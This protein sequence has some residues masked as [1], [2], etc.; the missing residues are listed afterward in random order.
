MRRTE[1]VRE[2]RPSA[3]RESARLG[4]LVRAGHEKLLLAEL[5]PGRRGRIE[6]TGFVVANG[7]PRD[8]DGRTFEPVFA[9]QVIWLEGGPVTADAAS[10]AE[11]LAPLVPE[12]P[13]TIRVEAADGGVPRD[14][15]RRIA[16]QLDEALGSELERR[17]SKAKADA[18][19]DDLEDARWVL[20]VVVFSRTEAALGRARASDLFAPIQGSRRKNRRAARLDDAF[21]LA[22]VAPEP[23]ERVVELGGRGGWASHAKTYGAKAFAVGARGVLEIENARENPFEYAATETWDWVLVDMPRRAV[24]VS[25]M[26][27]KWGRRGWARQVAATLRLPDRDAFELL[28]ECRAILEGAGWKGVRI[29]QLPTDGAEVTLTAWLDPKIAARGPQEPFGARMREKKEQREARA[30][31]RDWLDARRERKKRAKVPRE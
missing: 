17:I 3:D 10:V 2:R 28:R 12:G 25:R 8:S 31:R 13:Y 26:L 9:R 23:G 11:A 1:R 6:G 24:E 27:G 15:R 4:Y 30:V 18:F 20:Q 29:R 14:P 7:Q 22:G 21:A 19:T 16:R 5:P